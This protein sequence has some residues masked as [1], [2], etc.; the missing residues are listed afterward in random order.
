MAWVGRLGLWWSKYASKSD[1]GDLGSPRA[2]TPPKVSRRHRFLVRPRSV[3]SGVR[4]PEI[5]G[6][7]RHCA[8]ARAPD[9]APGQRG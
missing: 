6:R 1:R 2:W 9:N 7:Q 8:A 4:C 3:A 5:A